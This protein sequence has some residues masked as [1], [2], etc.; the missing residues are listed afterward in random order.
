MSNNGQ[1]EQQLIEE[2]RKSLGAVFS[3]LRKTF[4]AFVGVIDAFNS[5]FKKDNVLN[6]AEALSYQPYAGKKNN[7][8]KFWAWFVSDKNPEGAD[9]IEVYLDQ[10]S[11]WMGKEKGYQV[12]EVLKYRKSDQDEFQVVEV[13]D[14]EKVEEFSI[15]IQKA[16]RAVYGYTGQIKEAVGYQQRPARPFVN[17]DTAD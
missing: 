12:F 6:S 2:P 3:D 7:A 17:A 16:T 11:R 1:S 8:P 9:Y 15:H 13:R 5:Q 14:P 10:V 4:Y